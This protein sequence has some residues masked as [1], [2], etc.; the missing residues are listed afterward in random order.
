MKYVKKRIA[1]VL[2]LFYVGGA[3]NMVYELAKNIDQSI[4]DLKIICIN[5]R[6]NT[7][8]EEK[9]LSSGLDVV[10][11]NG[12]GRVNPKGISI[13]WRELSKF[14]PDI[15]H[16]H[17]GGTIFSLPWTLLHGVMLIAT[18]HTIP[19]KAFNS[20][21]KKVMRFMARYNKAILVTVSDEN[22]KNTLNYFRLTPASVRKINNGINMD[23]FY[24]KAHKYFTYI[25]VGRHDRVKNQSMILSAFSEIT[26]V[27]GN[28]KL[29]LVGDG[30]EHE[31]LVS[32]ANDLGISDKVEFTG[33]VSSPEDYLAVSDVYI[34]S[35]HREGLPLSVLEAM[36]AK[37]PIISTNVGG[38]KDIVK[39]N[40]IL[41]DDNDVAGLIRVMKKL[42]YNS[43]LRDFMG[44]KS[45]EIVQLYS[46]KVMAKS[47]CNLYE[48]N[49]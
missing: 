1:I 15:V 38:M 16:T 17:L 34:Q 32:Q 5:G 3:E 24:R 28:V 35:S 40:G 9:V 48:E 7:S 4:Y 39:D 26:N 20:K 44:N 47:Y 42:Y 10:F 41:I 30:E 27:C 33:M 43:E 12:V 22:Y 18:L 21:V 46:S 37:L 23:R 13:V 49:I 29:I 11:L 2:G 8:L 25:N 36:S 31:N 19:E 6:A 45:W 14:K